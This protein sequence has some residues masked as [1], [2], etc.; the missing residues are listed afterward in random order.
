MKTAT[1]PVSV[2]GI[3]F[4]ALITEE[5]SFEAEVPEYSVEDGFSVSDT[6]IRSPLALSMTLFVTDTPVTWKNRFKDVQDR[7]NTVCKQ[8]E[9]L[10][11]KGE[12]VTVITSDDTYK[13][14]AIANITLTKDESGR[15]SREIPISFKQIIVTKART[16]TIPASYYRSGKSSAS[17]GTASTSS[18]STKSSGS[19]SKSSGSSSS[20]KGSKDESKG[21]ILYNVGSNLGIC[22]N[23]TSGK[24]NKSGK[25]NTSMV[26]A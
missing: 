9:E 22:G 5:K 14:M 1:R 2:G 16:T 24:S 10:Y 18:G 25:N 4:D 7:V 19:S 12:P 20:S 6:I 11:F 26:V 15:Y 23:Q 21:S 13:D 17:A 8:L 3:E